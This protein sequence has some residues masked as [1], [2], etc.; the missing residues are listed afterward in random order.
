MGVLMIFVIMAFLMALELPVA[1][2]VHRCKEKW[3]FLKFVMEFP[4]I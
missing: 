2:E 1:E 4:Q 3:N